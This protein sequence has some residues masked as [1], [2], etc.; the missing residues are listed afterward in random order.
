M[1]EYAELYLA[2]GLKDDA[3][4]QVIDLLR[5]LISHQTDSSSQQIKP[6]SLPTHQFFSLVDWEFIFAGKSSAFYGEN[7][8]SLIRARNQTREL[9]QLTVRASGRELFE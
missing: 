5:F 2:C 9:Y 8:S 6:L 3:P 1:P 4:Q 7:F